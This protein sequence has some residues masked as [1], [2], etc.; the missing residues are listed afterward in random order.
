VV[1]VAVDSL[2]LAI[3]TQALAVDLVDIIQTKLLRL[4]RDKHIP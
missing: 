4:F 1:A 3:V 2:V